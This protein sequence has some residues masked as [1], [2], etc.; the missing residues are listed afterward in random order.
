[1]PGLAPAPKPYVFLLEAQ[2]RIELTQTDT[3]TTSGI[4]TYVRQG[5]EAGAGKWGWAKL[6]QVVRESW[7]NLVL[8]PRTIQQVQA[9]TEHRNSR[10]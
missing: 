9:L 3:S 10:K 1:M 8:R 2:V 6:V 4:A 5:T 7:T